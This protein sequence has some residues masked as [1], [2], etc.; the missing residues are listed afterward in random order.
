M[1]PSLLRGQWVESRD[2]HCVHT[3][4]CSR[5]KKENIRGLKS[6]PED[7]WRGHPL[8]RNARDSV[9]CLIWR[10]HRDSFLPPLNL[11]RWENAHVSW[12]WVWGTGWRQWHRVLILELRFRF[13]ILGLNVFC[14]WCC[15]YGYSHCYCCISLVLSVLWLLLLLLWYYYC[16]YGSYCIYLSTAIATPISTITIPM[17]PVFV[18]QLLILLNFITRYT[19]NAFNFYVSKKQRTKIAKLW[20]KVKVLEFEHTATAFPSQSIT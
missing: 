20:V 17:S 9:N 3:C 14:C 16:Q 4:L 6:E 1:V 18:P 10:F 11:H 19:H 2:R 7:R 12:H 8:R 15:C 13:N 5:S